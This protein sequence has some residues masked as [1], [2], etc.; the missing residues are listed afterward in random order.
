MITVGKAMKNERLS[1]DEGRRYAKAMVLKAEAQRRSTKVLITAMTCIAV[2]AFVAVTILAAIYVPQVAIY[3]PVLALALALALQQYTAS[4]FAFFV[5]TFSKIYD[6]GDRIR[7][8]NTKGDVRH[9]GLLHTTLEEVGGGREIRRRA[10]RQA[11][12]RAQPHHTGPAG[13]ELLQGLLDRP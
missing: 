1:G 4:F 6:M 13:I 7:I 10:D 9:I 12:V 5:I 11:A 8:G 3:V 2:L